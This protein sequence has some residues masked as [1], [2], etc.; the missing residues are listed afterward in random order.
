MPRLEW[1]NVGATPQ[2][3]Q[4]VRPRLHHV[5][6][7]GLKLW[8]TA[9]QEQRRPTLRANQRSRHQCQPPTLQSD[10]SL[11]SAQGATT[12]VQRNTLDRSNFEN[13]AQ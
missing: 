3:V 7:L 13:F 9:R 2:L 10:E 11:L 1:Q 8:A 4:V 5:T 6:A 12:P